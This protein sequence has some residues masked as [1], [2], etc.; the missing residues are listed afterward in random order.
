MVKKVLFICLGN[1]CRSPMAEAVFLHLIKEQGVSA[2]WDVDSAGIGGWHAGKL[3]DSRCRQ[4]LQKYKIQYDGRARQIRK[5]DFVKYDYIF[6][7]DY[8]NMDDLK[9]L[10]KVP[11]IKSELLLL[12]DFDPQGE[13]IIRDPY[14]DNGS[15][16]FEKCYEQC[17]RCCSAF[18]AEKNT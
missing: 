11:N 10:A 15:E 16:G 1:I 13:K 5:N 6:G 17:M 2:D 14:Y 4:V 3:P 18:L 7:M 12:G 9:R 8:E